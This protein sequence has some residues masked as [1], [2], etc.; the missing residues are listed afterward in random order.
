[1]LCEKYS[2]LIERVFLFV[3]DTNAYREE[4]LGSSTTALHGWAVRDF[5]S[6]SGCEQMVTGPI[7]IDGRELDLVLTDTPC[8]NSG[9]LASW[10]L[11]S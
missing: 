2:L 8:R 9:S 10:D 6:L 7:H 11:K 1:M 3:G 4:W 5:A